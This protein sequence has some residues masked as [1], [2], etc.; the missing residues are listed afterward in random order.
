MFTTRSAAIE[1]LQILNFIIFKT[2]PKGYEDVIQRRIYIF[3]ISP[4]PR[5]YLNIKKAY[6]TVILCNVET[7]PLDTA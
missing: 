5:K 7:K 6:F 2:F 4:T 1:H 3:N